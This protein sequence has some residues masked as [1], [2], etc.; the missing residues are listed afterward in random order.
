MLIIK[1]FL[2]SNEGKFR[3]TCELIKKDIQAR[4]LKLFHL[5]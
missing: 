4:E 3:M 1:V 2:K 5:R